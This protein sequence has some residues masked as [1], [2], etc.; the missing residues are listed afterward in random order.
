VRAQRWR[1]L[2]RPLGEVSLYP[3]LSATAIGFGASSVLPF[4]VGELVRPALL[5]RRLGFGMSAAL[6]TIVL[7]RLFDM[8]FVILCFLVVSLA[9]PVPPAL[10]RGA[11]ALSAL[12]LVG[13]GVLFAMQRR[14]AA[15]RAAL[16][17]LLAR[18][19]RRV[20]AALRP[21][22][23]AFL[24]GL[25]GLADLATVGLVLG[26]SVYLWSVVTLTFVFGLLALGTD[27]PLL[28]ASLTTVVVVA[29]FVFLPQAPGFVGTWQAG[30]VLALGFFD[31]PRDVAVGYSL[32]TWIVSM[33]MNVGAAG[34]FLARE[35]LSLAQLWR[36]SGEPP[37][38]DGGG[39]T[40]AA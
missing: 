10:R 29:A 7:E 9:Y 28:A 5:G 32:L 23:R 8:L 27:V 37:R 33:V 2:L 35:D 11:F 22:A 40:D 13:F 21:M 20:G 26:Y 30:C 16:E 24:D 39:V 19:P 15:S 34:I 36:T 6:S 14:P 4:R 3:A 12:A 18:L 17:R 38:T 1:V 31:V 25:G